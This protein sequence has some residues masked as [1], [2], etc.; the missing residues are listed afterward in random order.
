[1]Q[2]VIGDLDQLVYEAEPD[3]VM[4]GRYS[5]NGVSYDGFTSSIA[6]AYALATTPSFLLSFLPLSVTF[7]CQ[8]SDVLAS[9]A[10]S[11]SS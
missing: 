7:C 1:M 4:L 2:S 8:L 10:L 5:E 6:A 11:L 9:S 3:G